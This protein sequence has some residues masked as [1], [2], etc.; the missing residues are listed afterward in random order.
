[1]SQTKIGIGDISLYLPDPSMDLKIL[2]ESRAVSHPQLQRVMNRAIE[3]TGQL[4]FRFPEPWEDTASMAAN[5]AAQT[6]EHLNEK[7]RNSIRY[8]AVGTETAVDHSKPAAAYVQGMLNEAGYGLGNAML[9]YEIKHACAGG[10]AALLSCAAMLSISG[11]L[12]EKALAITSDIARYDAPSTAEITQGAGAVSLLI[13]KNPR[14]IE[15]DLSNQG[16]FSSDVDDFFRPL[17]SVTARVK[18]RYS[19]ECYQEALE[20]AFIDYCERSGSSPCKTIEEIDYIALHVPFTRMPE[21]ALKKML[22]NICGKNDAEIAEFMKKT[23]FLDAMYLNQRFGNLYNASLYTYLAA[24]LQQEYARIAE[25]IV[26]KKV[27]IASYGS[28][29]TMMVFSG[30]IAAEAPEVI[31]AWDLDKWNRSS[32]QVSFNEYLE[33]L[34]RPENID[35]W[36]SILKKA[37]PKKDRFYLKDFG[38]TGLRIYSRS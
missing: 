20:K 3:N 2:M 15:I 26:G 19:M 5:A 28:G 25:G 34:D 11:R 9:T 16:F 35:S 6:M 4:S 33:W 37:K 1:M 21:T 13:E 22:R 38:E 14:L 29:N 36:R 24:L 8:I 27:M 12:N 18:G 7:D 31:R 23:G 32:R 17:D 30:I 10:T